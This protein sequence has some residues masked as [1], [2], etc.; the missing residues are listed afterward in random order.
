MVERLPITLLEQTQAPEGLAIRPLHRPRRA[1]RAAQ[2]QPLRNTAREAAEARQQLAQRE[3]PRLAAMAALARLHLSLAVASL[4][5]AA[6]AVEP[7]TVERQVLVALVVVVP[8]RQTAQQRQHLEPQ[9]QAVVAAVVE[10]R[11]TR[12]QRPVQAA[13]ASSS[14][15]TPYPFNLS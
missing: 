5:L 4:T 9:T 15:S 3:R 10:H 7:T 11:L 2:V 6:V 12:L 13:P 14:S 1:A 8:E